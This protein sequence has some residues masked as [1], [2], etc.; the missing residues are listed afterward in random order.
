MFH[1]EKEESLKLMQ[2]TS[3]GEPILSEIN[4]LRKSKMA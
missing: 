1:E 3:D 4:S 2:Q